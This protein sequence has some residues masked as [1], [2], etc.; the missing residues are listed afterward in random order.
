MHPFDARQN[1]AYKFNL[2]KAYDDNGIETIAA[3]EIHSQFHIVFATLY[4]VANSLWDFIIETSYAT[5]A[6][7][8]CEPV[9][10][11]HD[12]L[13]YSHGVNDHNSTD[14]LRIMGMFIEDDRIVLTLTKIAHD[15]L[16]PIP[17]GQ[18]RT[19]GYGWLVFERVT[20]TIIRV[21]HS[22]L[23]LAPMTSHGVATLDEMGHLFGI[24]RRFSETSECFLERIH[25]AAES[26]YLEKYPP[27][28]RRFQQY[29]SQR[30]R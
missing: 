1:E 30:P 23:H 29:V 22:D 15:E 8:T 27:W 16:F 25:T 9:N 26:T 17:P 12:R 11:F 6:L 7:V 19:H 24:P 20:D 3:M 13:I 2:H 28:I 5:S 4:D 21:R 14:L 10:F 18:A